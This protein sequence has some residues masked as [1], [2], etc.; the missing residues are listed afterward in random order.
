M[1]QFEVLKVRGTQSVTL[2]TSSQ[3]LPTEFARCEI[4]LLRRRSFKNDFFTPVVSTNHVLLLFPN[5]CAP[6][7]GGGNSNAAAASPA[8]ARD[9]LPADGTSTEFYVTSQAQTCIS[10][11]LNR[12]ES[13][14]FRIVYAAACSFSGC[15][16]LVLECLDMEDVL[17]VQQICADVASQGND[18]RTSS[19]YVKSFTCAG[20]APVLVDGQLLITHYYIPTCPLCGDRLESTV[21]GHPPQTPLCT[22]ARGGNTQQCT[23]FLSS[24]CFVCRRFAE[25]LEQ[26][27][28]PSP[29]QQQQSQS[30]APP[31]QTIKCEACA[32]AGDPWICLIC[33][34]VGCSRYQAMHAKDH[35]VAHQHFFSMNLLTQQIWDYDGDCFVHRV[36][37][38]LDTHTG[39]STRMQF[40]GRED[41]LLEDG[42]GGAAVANLPDTPEA[43][44]A[45]KKSISAKYDKK[46]ISS[47]TQYAMVIKS[48]L[49]AKRAFYESQLLEEGGAE[50]GAGAVDDEEG[51]QPLT[52]EEFEREAYFDLAKAFEPVDSVMADVGARRRKVTTMF[53]AVKNLEHELDMRA[54]ETGRLEK[55]LEGLKKELRGVIQQNV[56]NDLRLSSSIHDMKETLQ[57]IA[58][59]AQTQRRLAARL[60]DNQVSHMVVSGGPAASSSGTTPSPSP[61]GNRTKAGKNNSKSPRK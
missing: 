24:A 34:Y 54:E 46:L 59:N 41:P 17:N 2:H 47:H 57:D 22:C 38:L 15:A 42:N 50:D 35:C 7:V 30:H 28:Q 45:E 12:I 27:R 18:E 19:L 8:L 43:W 55:Q 13:I 39:S 53:Y 5:S 56:A 29:Q 51:G 1:L 11:F 16:V 25:S 61:S 37:I 3:A 40:P 32:K 58:L 36:V 9:A 60:G 44:K 33:G 6:V 21:S 10:H 52:S 4:R 23:C 14:P 20:G 26:A 48:E 31:V 49:D